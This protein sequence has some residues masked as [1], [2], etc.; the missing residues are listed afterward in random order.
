[1]SLFSK[2]K[3]LKKAKELQGALAKETVTGVSSNGHVTVVMDG[4][5]N[6]VSVQ[7]SEAVLSDK[8]QLERSTKEAFS[9]ALDALKKMNKPLEDFS[10]TIIIG[11][12]EDDRLLAKN[13]NAYFVDAL[14]YDLK[15]EMSK[16]EAYL[17]AFSLASISR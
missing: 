11:D 7:I 1:M 13:L 14:S 3:D 6:I 12:S 2:L 4:N 17:S 16:I 9:R 8:V 15:Q 5:Q 10:A